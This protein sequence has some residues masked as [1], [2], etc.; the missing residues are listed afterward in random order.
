MIK[1]NRREN[2]LF[3]KYNEQIVIDS[4]KKDFNRKCYLC[5][6]VTRHFEIEHFYPQKIYLHLVNDYSN[7][8]Y[9]CQ[10]CNKIKPK[11]INTTS[12]NEI[13]NCCE[14]NIE[15]YIKLRLNILECKIEIIKLNS[16]KN[17]DK[18]IDNTI[19]LLD[20]IYNGTHSKSNSCEDLKD[21][22]KNIIFEFEKKIE[23]Y[24]KSRLKRAI[25]EDIKEKLDIKSPY[26]SFKR[27]IIRDNAILKKEFEKY[28]ID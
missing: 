11:N 18:Q 17:L 13:I 22:I 28:I 16:A 24:Q 14:I 21:D 26:S 5:E 3:T 12:D 7:L 9:S 19:K 8:F 23:Q 25:I 27:W 1:V 4:L 6:E 2:P 20:R 15:K 10:K